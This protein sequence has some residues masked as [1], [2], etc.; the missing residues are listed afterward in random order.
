[1]KTV[2]KYSGFLILFTLLSGFTYYFYPDKGLASDKT[3]QKLVID[4]SQR[5][6]KVYGKD[7][8]VLKTYPVSLGDNPKGD[9]QF[10]G[11][12]KTPEGKYTIH[13]KNPNSNF[14]LNLGI[15]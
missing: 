7:N 6:L 5:S 14:H 2:L 13:A 1:M 15:S 12:Q 9:K 4:K 8:L 10:Q 3:I 11:D